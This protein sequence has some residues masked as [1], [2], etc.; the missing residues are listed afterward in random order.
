MKGIRT[1]SRRR[2]TRRGSKKGSDLVDWLLA[3]DLDL[4][5]TELAVLGFYDCLENI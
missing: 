4:K 3:L 1:V 2:E 5:S